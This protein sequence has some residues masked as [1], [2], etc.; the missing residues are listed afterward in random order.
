MIYQV[1][2]DVEINYEPRNK[3]EEIM[4]NVGM[5]LRVFKEEQ[6]LNR[7]FSFDSELIDKN[8]DVVTNLMT[9]E[10]MQAVRNYEPRAS[11]K[12]TQIEMIDKFNNDFNIIVSLEVIL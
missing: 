4:T 12:G 9:S 8:I 3:L 10:I 11:V 1:R 5:I 6:P 2:S 7:A